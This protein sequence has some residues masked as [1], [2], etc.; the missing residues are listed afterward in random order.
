VNGSYL[1]IG[2][3]TSGSTFLAQTTIE[4]YNPGV[5]TNTLLFS[6]VLDF[7]GTSGYPKAYIIPGQG[8]VYIFALNTFEV[9]SQTTGLQL[10]RETWSSPDNGKTWLPYLLEGRRSGDYLG[11]NCLLP[12]HASRGYV[13][14]IALFG[15]GNDN[16]QNQTARNDVA[17][18]V[19]SAPAPKR[20][21]Y[22]TD[23]MPYGRVVSD[24]TLQPNGKILITNGARIGFS[25]G[26][27]AAPNMAA[28]ANGKPRSI[29]LLWNLNRIML[30][31]QDSSDSLS[32][33]A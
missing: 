27:V 8:D 28:A 4:F 16:M 31:A 22:D 12:L 5:P 29:I 23:T 9:I 19:I 30:S 32:M 21:T 15:G 26:L 14:E 33:T 18:M 1:I 11:G 13:G 20:W 17:R 10:E 6:A 2:G 24:C 7:T 3:L 25:G